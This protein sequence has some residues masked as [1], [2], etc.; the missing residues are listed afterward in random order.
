VV[1]VTTTG[2]QAYKPLKEADLAGH[3]ENGS[4]GHG[5]A[6]GGTRSDRETKQADSETSLA[7]EDYALYEAL[8][9]LKGLTLFSP[10]GN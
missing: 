3:L 7:Q 9:L 5:D 10:A 2:S 6:R 1:G 4:K 8:N